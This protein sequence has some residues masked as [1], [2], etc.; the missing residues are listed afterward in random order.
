[1]QARPADARPLTLGSES[2]VNNDLTAFTYELAAKLG[3]APA[4]LSPPEDTL[5]LFGHAPTTPRQ[6]NWTGEWAGLYNQTRP[7]RL[8]VRENRATSFRGVMEYPSED[9]VTIVEGN[10]HERWSRADELWVQVN[11]GVLEGYQCAVSFKE[12]GYERKGRTSISFDGEYRAFSTENYMSGAWFSGGQLVGFIL[13]SANLGSC[14]SNFRAKAA[15]WDGEPAI[16]ADFL[17]KDACGSV[18]RPSASRA[19]T[20]APRCRGTR[21]ARRR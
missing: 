6:A 1:M 13:A 18:C 9:T 8:L 10:I 15:L 21:R 11:Q 20:R 3:R 19:R 16:S 14:H 17:E 4:A 12:T 2:Q 5:S 7:I